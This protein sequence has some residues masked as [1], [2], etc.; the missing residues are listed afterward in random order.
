MAHPGDR[1]DSLGQPVMMRCAGHRDK[2]F[3]M[4]TVRCAPAPQPSVVVQPS[5]RKV[6]CLIEARTRSVRR[7]AR[8][9]RSGAR[10]DSC[11]LV[12]MLTLRQARP[13]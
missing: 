2:P 3:S 10:Q 5:E 9:S 6:E 11:R 12:V 8:G 7:T 1:D 4:F 13:R